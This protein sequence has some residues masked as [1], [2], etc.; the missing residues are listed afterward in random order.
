MAKQ[1][2][3]ERSIYTQQIYKRLIATKPGDFISYDELTKL[4]GINVQTEGYGYR[5]SATRIA[6]VEDKMVFGVIPNDGI[7]RLN[8]NEI[9]KLGDSSIRKIRKESKNG[10][11][12]VTAVQDFD[13][14]TPESKM[15]H[16]S[17]LSVLAAF[18]HFTKP[19]NIL[20]IESVVAENQKQ[21]NFDETLSIFK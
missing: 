6:L 17:T 18:Q 15:K 3:Q 12:K 7:K 14:L 5:A 1:T 16:N 21:I 2:I 10:I 8:D 19:R 11:R 4:I 9:A 13:A 20:K